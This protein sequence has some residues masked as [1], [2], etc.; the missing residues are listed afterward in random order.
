MAYMPFRS[1]RGVA[2]LALLGLAAC[3][4]DPASPTAGLP[5]T[6]ADSARTTGGITIPPAPAPDMA[7]RG[8]L[9]SAMAGL[10]VPKLLTAAVLLASGASRAFSARYDAQP[11]VVRYRTPGVDGRLTT[12]SGAV[13]LPAG[14]TGALP[15]VV[16][17]HGT[18]TKKTSAPSYLLNTPEGD[19]F[20]STYAADGSML[21]APDYLGLGVAGDGTYHPYLHVQTE[22]SAAVDL[23]RAARTL[24][25]QRGVSLEPRVFVTGY[26]QGG[27]AAMGLFRALERDHASEIPVL[28][29]A[30]MSGPYDLSS[31]ARTM[32]VENADYHAG[33]VYTAY[34][35]AS[36]DTLYAIAPRLSDLLASPSDRVAAHLRDG[37]ATDAELATLP[38]H[39][40][41]VLRADVVAAMLSNPDHPVWRAARD[42]DAYDW[43]PRAPVRLYYGGADRDV[44]NENA[45]TAAARMRANG[46]ANVAAVNVGATLDHAGAV[47]PATIAG[48]L[49][50]DSLRRGQIR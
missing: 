27:G 36:L 2:A 39:P 8:E 48:K 22:A 40:R 9:V 7:G 19:V 10:R 31:T 13:W 16:Y 49:F 6:T 30:P 38:S 42:N 1:P 28:G 14:A 26:S 41:D 45:L 24:A 12:A 25:E 50:L 23:L 18:I 20:G 46:A 29:A 5:A 21:V 4:T 44:P 17:M 11:Y 37:T 3:T 33:A 35:I 32:L 47:L 15:V 43:T 34:L